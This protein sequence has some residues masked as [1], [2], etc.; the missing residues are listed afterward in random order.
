[1]DV[2]DPSEKEDIDNG[3]KVCNSDDDVERV[4]GCDQEGFPLAHLA[5]N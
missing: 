5:E 1:M 2:F 3:Q 4:I